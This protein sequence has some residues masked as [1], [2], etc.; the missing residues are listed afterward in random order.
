MNR[1]VFEL[2]LKSPEGSGV[3]CTCLKGHE[4]PHRANGGAV[5]WFDEPVQVRIVKEPKP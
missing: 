4:P 5:I 3:V 2:C 1:P